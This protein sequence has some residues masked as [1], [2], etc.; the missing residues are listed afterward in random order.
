MINFNKNSAWDLFPIPLDQV[1]GEVMG[2]LVNGEQPDG[3][4]DRSRPA[5][6][7]EQEN[8]FHRCAGHYRQK[9]VFH[10]SSLF[11]DPVFRDPDTRICGARSGLRACYHVRKWLHRHIRIQRPCGYQCDRP[12]DFRIRSFQIMSVI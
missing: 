4:Q 5:R 10:L 6:F 1:R 8:H 12:H 9:K 3:L 11:Q 7:H 2:L